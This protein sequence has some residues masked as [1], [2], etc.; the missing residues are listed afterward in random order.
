MNESRPLPPSQPQKPGISPPRPTAG[1][2]PATP[3]IGGVP[4]SLAKPTEDEL[5]PIGLA[6]TPGGT[7]QKMIKAFGAAAHGAAKQY[8]RRT[9]ANGTGACRVRSFH[10]RLS[11]EGMAFLDDKINEWLDQHPE[12]EVKF[13]TSTIG[14]FEGKIREVALVLNLWY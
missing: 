7:S 9:S 13:V 3:K 5:A 10:G 12:V 4:S 6:D 2:A 14:Q 11:E 8:Q 1:T